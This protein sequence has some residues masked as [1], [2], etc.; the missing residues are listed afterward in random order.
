MVKISAG[1]GPEIGAAL[2]RANRNIWGRA[3]LLMVPNLTLGADVRYW[4]FDQATKVNNIM[5]DV[6]GVYDM[7]PLTIIWVAFLG[8]TEDSGLGE[9]HVMVRVPRIY[10]Q[11]G[12]H[13]ARSLRWPCRALTYQAR[14]SS[15][16]LSPT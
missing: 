1:S 8:S 9:S 7:K 16:R 6:Q 15:I 14:E 2:N 5:A 12:G 3:Q 11:H 10:L 13:L 4:G